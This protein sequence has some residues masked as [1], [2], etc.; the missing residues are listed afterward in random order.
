M[1]DLKES[2]WDMDTLKMI[3][4]HQLFKIQIPLQNFK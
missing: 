2:K 4:S 1:N 3:K